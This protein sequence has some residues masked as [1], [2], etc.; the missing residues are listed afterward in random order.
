MKKLKMFSLLLIA[1]ISSFFLTNNVKAIFTK[2]ER[3][4]NIFSIAPAYN[5]TYQYH[6][7]NATGQVIEYK[8]E[9]SKLVFGTTYQPIGADLSTDLDYSDV[10]FYVNNEQYFSDTY[11]VNSDTVVDEVYLL[12]RYNVVFEYHYVNEFDRY[13]VLA[14][15][16]SEVH[17]KGDQINLVRTYPDEDYSEI[18]Y[19]INGSFYNGSR[20]Y[21]VQGA[22][23]IDE[24]Y[25]LKRYNI[26]YNL[27]GGEVEN[28]NPTVYTSRT[29]TITL[30]NPEKERYEFI[31]WTWPGQTE[32]VMDVSFESTDKENKTFTANYRLL[33]VPARVEY[34]LMDVNGENYVL[35]EDASHTDM[36]LPGSDFEPEVLYYE[37]FKSPEP[38][39][40][41]VAEDGSTVVVYQYERLKYNLTIE[42]S[43]YVI[44]ETPSGQYYYGTPILLTAVP[45]DNN[46]NSFAKWSNGEIVPEVNFMMTQDITIKPLYGN[47]YLVEF[48]PNG[49]SP[50]PAFI[51]VYPGEMVGTLPVV[52]NDDCETSEGSYSERNCTYAY[53]FEGWYKEETFENIVHEDFIPDE[54]ITLYAK[55]SKVYYHNDQ[56]VFTGNNMIDTEIALFSEE[57]ASKDF[58]VTFTLDEL[59][60][61]GENRQAIFADLNEKS[62]PFAGTMFRFEKNQN[63]FEL[64]AN[65][66]TGNGMG[67]RKTET[68]GD[69]GVGKTFVLIRESGKLYYSIDDGEY[70]LFNDFSNFQSQF[71]V[72]ATFGGEYDANLD[73]YRYLV[74]TLSN[75]T[76]ELYDSKTYTVKFNANGGEG[77]M[78]DQDFTLHGSHALAANSYT[79]YGYIFSH[80][81]TNV[82]G[83]GDRYEN[84]Q[85]VSALG[86][87]GEI[88]NLYAQWEEA[89]R[90]YVAFDANGGTGSMENQE[91]IFDIAQPLNLSEYSKEGYIFDSWNTEPDGSG[92]RY[93]EG[94]IV[95][96]LTNVPN[97]VITLY[98]QYGKR[99]Y[100]HDGEITFDGVDDYIDTGVNIYSGVN[101]N[102]DFD[103]SFDLIYADQINGRVYQPTILNAKDESH[104]ISG[105]TNM[106]PGFVVRFNGRYSPI[107]IK[108][109]WGSRD[110]SDNVPTGNVPIHFEFHRR[111]GVVT[112]TYSYNDGANTHTITLY[113]QSEWLLESNCNSNITIGAIVKNGVPDRFFTGT[114]AD[115][116]IVV[117]D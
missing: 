107:D 95:T 81:T 11:Q 62:S 38:V 16:R 8:P 73:E 46:G 31:G 87:E 44:T 28:A 21:T 32:P 10:S 36:L 76:V 63:K 98:A 56:T 45:H 103:I 78:L 23:T 113:D 67:K 66:A 90:Y 37:G 51:R 53:K 77:V 65:V 1:I 115:I 57:N 83:T 94:E 52:T 50:S 3:V 25:Y 86:S 34:W 100:H 61:T 18:K 72:T 49:G 70:I 102:K 4:D 35:D 42:N 48:E 75:M 108:A 112:S 93:E 101:I 68:I 96:N 15:S 88:I 47:P 24:V 2:S 20:I 64:V 55:W 5:F 82:D 29:G 6:Y 27:D 69:F 105:T 106:V 54:D 7:I 74:G 116:D 26:T 71:D 85:V 91:L 58:M 39:S 30:N 92:T 41:Q 79:R 9:V 99:E 13:V 40:V 43:E 17:N 59:A 114:L 84:E 89:P 14:D 19:V 12:T 110:S 80:W 104:I 60:G 109:R 22:D 111:G 117:Y 97:E 33:P